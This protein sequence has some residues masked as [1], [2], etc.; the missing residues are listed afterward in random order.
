MENLSLIAA[1]GS[2]NELGL[3]NKLIWKIKEDL[4]FH[5]EKTLYQNIIM[6]R[7]TFESMPYKAL[8]KR[9]VFVISSKELDRY[10]DTNT[11]NSVESML[12]Y[13]KSTPNEN[14]IV[15]GGAQ[16]YGAFLPYVQTM[17]LTEIDAYAAAD[18]FFPYIELH[19]WEVEK[20]FEYRKND[21]LD[22]NDI[23]Y[24]RNRYVRRRIK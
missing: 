16:I 13:I 6:G 8:E 22:K 18:T 17:Y 2:C 5:R 3:D 7:K 4:I 11:Y 9:N 15:V 1:I 14:F 23:S 21:Y 19:E 24:V 12:E 10:C 20:E